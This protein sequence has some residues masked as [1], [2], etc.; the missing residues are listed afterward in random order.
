MFVEIILLEYYRNRN[1]YQSKI[2]FKIMY[3]FRFKSFFLC[4]YRS[5]YYFWSMMLVS[6]VI[7][8]VAIPITWFK[9]LW[10]VYTPY[11]SEDLLK[12][13]RPQH[14][15]LRMLYNFSDKIMESFTSRTII[16]VTI[17]LLLVTCSLIYLVSMN[18][19][20]VQD[21]HNK[22]SPFK[23]SIPFKVCSA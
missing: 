3:T 2:I 1:R 7:L 23:N 8:L 18:M 19:R 11:S 17:I 10:D 4:F 9:K 14:A 6:G 12:V 5:G 21:H 20:Q 16:Y 15:I 13:R 22:L